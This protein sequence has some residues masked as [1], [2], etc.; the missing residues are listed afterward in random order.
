METSAVTGPS[1]MSSYQSLA[2]LK[3]FGSDVMIG[4]PEGDADLPRPPRNS[5]RPAEFRPD[6]A[7]RN[8]CVLELTRV[9]G[10]F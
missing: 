8:D 9:E 5:S 1:E 7:Q 3:L 10:V 4:A 2:L 6:L